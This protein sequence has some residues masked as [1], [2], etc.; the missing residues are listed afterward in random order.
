[1]SRGQK[2][3]LLGVLLLVQGVLLFWALIAVLPA[4]LEADRPTPSAGVRPCVSTTPTPTSSS[5]PLPSGTPSQ[6]AATPSATPSVAPPSPGVRDVPIRVPGTPCWSVSSDSALPLLVIIV[7]ALGALVHAA[8][9][10]AKH[11]SKGT[12][13]A[14]YHWWYVLR[15]MVGAGL[16]TIFYFVIRGGL[17]SITADN[18]TPNVYGI[19]AVA[20]LAGLFSYPAMKRLEK[21]FERLGASGGD[22]LSGTAKP[23][24]TDI[25]PDSVEAGATDRTITITGTGFGS[26]PGISVGG[27][28]REY[29]GTA[30]DM[31]V[32]VT[33][34]ADDVAEPGTLAVKVVAN[35]M[36]SDPHQVT[37]TP[38]A[39]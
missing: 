21:V 19:T 16:S 9:S 6:P 10:F 34:K 8:T 24:I 22:D 32:T 29:D 37:V 36:W 31:S 30:T 26:D 1:M 25:T 17:L 5:T 23:V 33:L 3:I 18:T 12:F 15:V 38:K 20:A 13:K 39:P 27:T 14:S 4:A 2:S 35:D 28:P 7:G 11:H